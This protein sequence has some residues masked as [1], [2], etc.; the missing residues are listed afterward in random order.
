ML[1]LA[2]GTITEGECILEIEKVEKIQ[3][4]EKDEEIYLKV[5]KE[6]NP[7]GKLPMEKSIFKHNFDSIKFENK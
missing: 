4:Q 3:W 5:I 1:R 7:A 6:C 2:K